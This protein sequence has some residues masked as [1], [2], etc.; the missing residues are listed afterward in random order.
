ML[1]PRKH[2][3]Q[4]LNCFIRSKIPFYT[5]VNQPSLT[6]MKKRDEF[7]VILER[8]VTDKSMGESVE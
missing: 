4:D 7:K 2:W 8:I 6:E 1:A 3:C 5:F